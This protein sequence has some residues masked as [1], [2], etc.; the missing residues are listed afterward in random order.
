M[1][2]R[3]LM[4][5]ESM[6]KGLIVQGEDESPPMQRKWNIVVKHNLGWF[7]KTRL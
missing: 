2:T 1:I 6:G 4:V 5:Y 7:E 3:K